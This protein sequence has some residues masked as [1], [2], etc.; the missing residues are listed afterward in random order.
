[1]TIPRN[2]S[3]L[4]QGASSTGVLS[5][6]YGGTGLTTLTAGYIPYGN[7]T[8][9]FN[10]S[11]NLFWDNTNN[12]LGIGTASPSTTLDVSFAGGMLRAGGAGGNNLLQSYSG[13][14]GLGLWAGGVSQI[15]G[16]GDLS[17]VAGVT[18]GTGLPT[19]GTTVA[20]M[21]SGGGMAVGT[22]NTDPA[23]SNVSGFAIQNSGFTS[24][25]NAANTALAL[26]ASG[27]SSFLQVF[28]NAGALAGYISVTSTVTTY[29]SV[30]DYRLKENI[31]PLN[32]SLDLINKLKP[33][34][35]TWI[36]NKTKGD[37]FIAHELQSLIPI[38]VQNEKDSVD[39]NGNPMYQAVDMS[40]IVPYLTKALQELSDKFD[41]YVASHP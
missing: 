18:I 23:G 26:G 15:Y 1:M 41:A 7:G 4:A 39:E 20:T 35:F 36:N 40:R 6:P 13:S 17:F 32:N 38:A 14:V 33:C 3:F 8:G 12:R 27:N 21:F 2:L 10:S 9:A 19:G 29:N 22:T 24:I 30:S 25:Q 5:V 16:T 37:G 34:T 11:A 31:Q 28:R